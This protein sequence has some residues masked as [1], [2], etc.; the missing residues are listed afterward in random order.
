MVAQT[1]GVAEEVFR[2]DTSRMIGVEFIDKRLFTADDELCR[3]IEHDVAN[4]LST[5]ESES[6]LPSDVTSTVVTDD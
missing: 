1:Q 5:E 3:I 6:Y 2:F 4:Y